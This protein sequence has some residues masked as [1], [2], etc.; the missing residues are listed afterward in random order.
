MLYV[1]ICLKKVDYEVV[2]KPI[3]E[4]DYLSDSEISEVDLEANQSEVLLKEEDEKGP[5][6]AVTMTTTVVKEEKTDQYRQIIGRTKEGI[7]I[8]VM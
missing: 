4:A 3:N 5:E 8:R 1:G 6:T 2:R 7:P